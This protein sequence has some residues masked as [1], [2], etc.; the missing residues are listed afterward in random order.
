MGDR[1]AG[2]RAV[3]RWGRGGTVTSTESVNILVTSKGGVGFP[4]AWGQ[5]FNQPQEADRQSQPQ[6]AW[7][8]SAPEMEA[9]ANTTLLNKL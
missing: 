2:D 5:E 1:W 8:L 9:A 7:D 6:G 3:G 4:S